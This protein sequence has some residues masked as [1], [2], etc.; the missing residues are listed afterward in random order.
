MALTSSKAAPQKCFKQSATP[1]KNEFQKDQKLESKD[2]RSQ[3]ICVATVI[4]NEGSRVRLRLDGSD[5]NNDFW[6]VRI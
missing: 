4:A 2:P 6:K 5:A 1:P 3:S